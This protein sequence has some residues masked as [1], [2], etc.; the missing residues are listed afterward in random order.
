ME[1]KKVRAKKTV[2]SRAF[3]SKEEWI[4]SLILSALAVGLFTFVIWILS[5]NFNLDL[6]LLL[7]VS[8][9]VFIKIT[10]SPIIVMALAV[11]FDQRK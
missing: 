5:R 9:T 8:I 4:V 2:D 3:G 1:N 11:T 10:V 7:F 6:A